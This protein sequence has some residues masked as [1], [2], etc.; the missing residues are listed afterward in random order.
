MYVCMHPKYVP[1]RDVLQTVM[2]LKALKVCK[3]M[4]AC[5]YVCTQTVLCLKAVKVCILYVYVCMYACMHPKYASDR[6]ELEGCQGMYLYV[7]AFMHACMYVCMHH[8]YVPSRDVLL[9]EIA[10][11]YVYVWH[12]IHI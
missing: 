5:M 9:T 7:Y 6:D 2:S 8:K 11:T 10:H 1:P 3:C 4:Y 12:N